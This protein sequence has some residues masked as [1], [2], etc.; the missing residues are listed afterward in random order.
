MRPINLLVVDILKNDH[1]DILTDFQDIIYQASNK[2]YRVNIDVIYPVTDKEFPNISIKNYSG[3][4]VFGSFTSYNENVYWVKSLRNFVLSV[5]KYRKVPLLGIC[6]A[7][8]LIG[9]LFGA[10]VKKNEIRE[11]GTICL[12][13]TKEGKR[14]KFFE[15]FSDF[16]EIQSAHTHDIIIPP[17]KAEI[18]VKNKRSPCQAFRIDNLYCVQF[19]PD[20]KVETLRQWLCDKENVNR[21]IEEGYIKDY[22]EIFEFVKTQFTYNDNH[23]KLFRNFLN[24]CS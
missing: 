23:I 11:I 6:M 7:H 14:S 3:I 17:K 19:H 1:I 13:L 20:I 8:Q 10:T 24:I 16:F 2:K 21:L 22:S 12:Q 15:G 4:V 18:L 9:D 5:Y